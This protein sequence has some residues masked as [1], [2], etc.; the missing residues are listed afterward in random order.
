MQGIIDSGRYKIIEVLSSDAS[1]EARLCI[2]VMVDND[3][4]LRIFNTYKDKESI[5]EYLPLFYSLKKE[6]CDDFIELVTAD[7][8]ISAVFDYHSGICFN[9]FFRK[10]EKSK[11]DEKLV[12]AERLLEAALELDLVDDR[13]AVCALDDENVIVD[14]KGQ[15]IRFN[16]IVSPGHELTENFRSQ[17]IGGMLKKIFVPDRFL[18]VEIKEFVQDVEENRLKTCVEIFARWRDIQEAAAQTR[19]AYEKEGFVKYLKRRANE[20][21]NLAKRK[22]MKKN[23]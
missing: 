4:D 19:K 11:Y 16:F 13:L 14:V 6:M 3:Y 20:K 17:A 10:H 18:P 12:Y 7:G 9:D 8:S 1:Y 2:D 15:V 5:R 21:K 23:G 22:L